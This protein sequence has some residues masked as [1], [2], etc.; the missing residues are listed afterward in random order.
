MGV[1]GSAVGE[2]SGGE[3]ENRLA[4]GKKL[5]LS[6]VL[7]HQGEADAFLGTSKSTYES[8][9]R[10]LITRTMDDVSAPWVVAQTSFCRDQENDVNINTPDAGVVNIEDAQISLLERGGFEEYVYPGPNTNRIPHNC[11]FD[12]KDEY[13]ALVTAWV[14]NLTTNGILTNKAPS[15]SDLPRFEPRGLENVYRF[16]SE[17]YGDHLFTNVKSEGLNATAYEYEGVGFSVFP[18]PKTTTSESNLKTLYRCI[19][20]TVG[21]HFVSEEKDCGGASYE[22]PYG[23]IFVNKPYAY[24]GPVIYFAK[25]LY[26]CRAFGSSVYL[27]TT[28][29]LA[30][31]TASGLPDVKQL[32]WMPF[33]D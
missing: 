24:L 13:D 18:I 4:I 15:T 25:P 21:K 32:G 33:D 17:K 10:S 22:G 12:R 6:G 26:T 2:W 30:E 29:S 20:T 31:C 11:H 7:W 14:T 8:K 27:I 1:G 28:P 5:R 19:N 3:L 16:F 9:L 23:K